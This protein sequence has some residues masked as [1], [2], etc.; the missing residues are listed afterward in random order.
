MCGAARPAF[1]SAGGFGPGIIILIPA[2]LSTDIPFFMPQKERRTALAARPGEG[3]VIPHQ[4]VS[5]LMVRVTA[6]EVVVFPLV[7]V[8]RQRKR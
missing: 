6:L 3:T 1:S 7:S 2:L 4:D 5:Y 8:I